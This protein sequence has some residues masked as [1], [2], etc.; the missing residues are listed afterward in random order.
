MR[1]LLALV[2][3][4]FSV[5]P[6]F[7]QP[8]ANLSTTGFQHGILAQ[9]KKSSARKARVV[10]APQ[11][12]L[13]KGGRL[14][15]SS[16]LAGTVV[17]TFRIGKYEV[18][19]TE[20]QKVRAWA[21]KNGFRDLATGNGSAA[22]HP[23]RDVN[24]YDAVKWCNAKSLQE[25]LVPVYRVRGAVYRT[26]EAEPEIDTNANGYRLP[27]EAEW[28]WA[29]RGGTAS[30]RF[31]YSGGNDLKRVGWY[32]ENAIWPEVRLISG[33]GTWPVGQKTANEL[34]LHDMSGN[35]REWCQDLVYD[36]GTPARPNRGGC[37]VDSKGICTVAWR[38][39]SYYWSYREKKIGL[40]LARNAG[41]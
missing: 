10:P 3:I 41:I 37:F 6:V 11:M 17:P 19:W 16:E 36:E 7:A 22:N 30:R 26:G 8:R 23:V 18:M 32:L 31:K 15:A 14:P 34:G 1:A 21:V 5:V 9:D 25:G 39:F 29:A 12:V 33:R 40:R 28:E 38:E 4:F 27:G 20:W 13:V 35:V 2:V 24:W